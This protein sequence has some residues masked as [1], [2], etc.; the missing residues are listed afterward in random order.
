V[1]GGDVLQDEFSPAGTV[2]EEGG[3]RRMLL[4][5]GGDMAVSAGD[6]GFVLAKVR[7]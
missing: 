3:Y 5:P 2:K 4:N 7:L 1:G 6:V